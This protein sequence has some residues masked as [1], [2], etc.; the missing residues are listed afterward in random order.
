MTQAVPNVERGMRHKEHFRTAVYPTPF[1]PRTNLVLI[2]Q[3]G[4]EYF[5]DK[6]TGR[7]KSKGWNQVSY[8]CTVSVELAK[9]FEIDEDDD[10]EDRPRK[11]KS[12]PDDKFS[13]KVCDC[14]YK[15]EIEGE[16]LTGS[17]VNFT[18][19]AMMIC[20]DVD[21]EHWR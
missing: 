8:E 5:D 16:E 12:N 20:P 15:T 21:E 3:Q 13:L 4:E 1:H 17:M 19:L 10:D 9:R 14:T 6:P 2:H 11:R 18:E 7:S